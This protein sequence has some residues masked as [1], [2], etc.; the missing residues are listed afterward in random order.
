MFKTTD[1]FLRSFGLSSIKE[2][3][4]LPEQETV[5]FGQQLSLPEQDAEVGEV[6]EQAAELNADSETEE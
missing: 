5:D 1:E 2:M 3:P 6:Q 4:G